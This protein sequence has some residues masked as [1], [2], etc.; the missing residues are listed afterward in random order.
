[1]SSGPEAEALL[2][3]LCGQVEVV[4]GLVKDGIRIIMRTPR[5]YVTIYSNQCKVS[6]AF[7]YLNGHCSGK[8][9][10]NKWSS[11]HMRQGKTKILHVEIFTYIIQGSRKMSIRPC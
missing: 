3:V 11:L 10:H 1:M 4:D 9:S 6:F 8:L 7:Y 2:A 5:Q